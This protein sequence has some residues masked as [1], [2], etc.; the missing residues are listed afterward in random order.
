MGIIET[1]K[2]KRQKANGRQNVRSLPKPKGGVG[3]V[4]TF[5]CVCVCA[6][7]CVC[8]KCVWRGGSTTCTQSAFK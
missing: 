1:L 2:A 3:V 5:Q 7:V 8:E 4:A 6:A